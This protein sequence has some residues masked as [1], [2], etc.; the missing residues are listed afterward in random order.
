MYARPAWRRRGPLPHTA[1][2]PPHTHTPCP[3][4]GTTSWLGGRNPFLGITYLATGG[5]SLLLGAAFLAARLL[6]PRK[7]GDPMLLERLKH[8]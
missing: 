4:Q 2:T 8:Q 7:F 6:R 5:A 3:L 1:P